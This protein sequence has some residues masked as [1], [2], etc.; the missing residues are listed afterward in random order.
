[1]KKFLFT[2]VLSLLLIEMPAHGVWYTANYSG[3]S[4]NE[5]DSNGFP[6][7]ITITSKNID[8][9]FKTTKGAKL[10]TGSDLETKLDSIKELLRDKD[11]TEFNLTF[12]NPTKGDHLELMG[13][14][15][16][17]YGRGCSMS[18]D[19]EDAYIQSHWTA[20]YDEKR[21]QIDHEDEVAE[22]RRSARQQQYD[23]FADS[24]GGNDA[25]LM[26]QFGYF[27]DSNSEDDDSY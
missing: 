15:L 24:N 7:R 2:V 10:L 22:E 20:M 26:K 17:R 12:R 16:D 8:I 21:A 27:S 19:T 18:C 13:S 6:N 9:Y 25:L 1:M 3:Y 14:V 23:D 11:A 4:D 5:E